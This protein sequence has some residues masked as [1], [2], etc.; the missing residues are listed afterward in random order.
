MN[1]LVRGM[2]SVVFA[3]V[4]QYFFSFVRNNE[5]CNDRGVMSSRVHAKKLMPKVERYLPLSSLG[6]YV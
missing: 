1:I 6:I 4:K 3:N 5:P 2:L